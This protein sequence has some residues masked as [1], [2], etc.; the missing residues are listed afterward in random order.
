M[1]EIIIEKPSMCITN[2]S[3]FTEYSLYLTGEI[4]SPE[5]YMEFYAVLKAANRGDA[6]RIYIS[7][8]GGQLATATL[9]KN[10]I[11]TCDAEVIGVLGTDVASAASDIALSCDSIEVGPMSCMLIHNFSYST[12]FSHAVSIHNQAQFNKDLNE[13]WVM[14]VYGDFLPPE[15]LDKVLDGVDVMLN[16]EQIVEYWNKRERIRG[17]DIGCDCEHCSCDEGGIGIYPPY[18]PDEEEQPV[19][20]VDGTIT[21]SRKV[22]GKV[23][24]SVEVSQEVFAR[25]K[26]KTIQIVVDAEDE[27]GA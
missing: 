7:S 21:N 23:R 8:C 11:E 16:A 27:D 9:I 14:G 10:H 6:V 1:S 4:T 24:M 15:T 20:L 19:D 12:G 2:T 18:D 3:Q 26:D 5:D 13:R 22:D 25:I 17:G